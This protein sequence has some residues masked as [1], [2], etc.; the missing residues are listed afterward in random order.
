MPALLSHALTCTNCD[1][2]LP[3]RP[4]VVDGLRYCC[5]KCETVD[6]STR[7][8]WCNARATKVIGQFRD[9]ACDR[10]AQEF[11]ETYA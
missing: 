5:R 3:P 6:Q 7:C 11:A 8:C 1:G 4:I 9:P 10:H 2:P